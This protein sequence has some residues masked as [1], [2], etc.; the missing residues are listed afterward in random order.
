[1]AAAAFRLFVLLAMWSVCVGKET[2]SLFS[3]RCQPAVGV[4]GEVTDISCSIQS[5]TPDTISIY[6][7]VL[8]RVGEKE[9]LF[10]FDPYEKRMSGEPRFQVTDKTSFQLSNTRLSDEGEYKYHIR[11]NQGGKETKFTISVTAKYREPVIS[12]KQEKIENDGA[13]DLLCQVSGGYPAGNI[14]WFDQ[15]NTNWTN[16]ATLQ[17]T[18][19]DDG[20]YNLSSTLSYRRFDT[21]WAPFK[22]VVLNSKYEEEGRSTSN[23]KISG[24]VNT[25]EGANNSVVKNSVAAVVVIGSLIVG[26]LIVILFKRKHVRRSIPR[27][28]LKPEEENALNDAVYRNSSDQDI[29]V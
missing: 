15:S 16:S 20:L 11:T 4:V 9:A 13:A 24:S 7:I 18:Q 21:S 25:Q 26:L 2:G 12:S 17:K 22:C 3:I 14:H 6:L 29:T 28:G 27:E 8:T 1:M 23:L 10:T 5:N 19:G